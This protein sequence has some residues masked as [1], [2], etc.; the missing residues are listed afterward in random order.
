MININLDAI[1]RAPIKK[2]KEM[3]NKWDTNYW[4]EEMKGKATL[5]IYS[6]YKENIKEISLYENSVK[7]KILIKAPT[8][9]LK[10]NWREKYKGKTTSCFCGY[11]IETLEHF[12]LDCEL[13]KEIRQKILLTQQPYR[14]NTEDLIAN[15]LAFQIKKENEVT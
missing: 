10:L 15:I 8:D 2:I 9:T 7:T 14:E 12:L 5:R 4:K 13:Y 11:E 3:V 6:K 1:K